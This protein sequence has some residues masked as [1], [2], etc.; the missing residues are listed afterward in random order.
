M[1]LSGGKVRFYVFVNGASFIVGRMVAIAKDALDMFRFFFTWAMF[2]VMIACAFDTPGA[3]KT[4]GLG[5]SIS[6]IFA[7]FRYVSL[8]SW[9]FKLHLSVF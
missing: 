6:L 1:F 2:S 4:V 7:A 9:W 5:M 3:V 8:K